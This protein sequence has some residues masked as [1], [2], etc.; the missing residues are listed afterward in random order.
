MRLIRL[1][2]SVDC[3]DRGASLRLERLRG[4]GA[5]ELVLAARASA[6]KAPVLPEVLTPGE[7]AF[8]EKV[9]VR[10]RMHE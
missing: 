10:L 2:R 6:V 7:L 3:L 5:R 9:G 8:A 1:R 4:S